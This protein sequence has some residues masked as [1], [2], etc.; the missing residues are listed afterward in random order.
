M[1][2]QI[3][4]GGVVLR[5]CCGDSVLIEGGEVVKMQWWMDSGRGTRDYTTGVKGQWSND[6]GGGSV[7]VV[8]V[9]W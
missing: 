1:V 7:V 4:D 8:V 2:K 9:N 3:S 6:D 5:V